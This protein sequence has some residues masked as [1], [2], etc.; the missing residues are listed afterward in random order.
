MKQEDIIT[1]FTLCDL[2]QAT[3]VFS[4]NRAPS[5]ERQGIMVEWHIK[6]GGQ[7]H[8]FHADT[9]ERFQKNLARICGEPRD[10]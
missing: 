9:L 6:Y 1:A 2:V 4:F 8:V 5:A 10:E 7:T 3:I